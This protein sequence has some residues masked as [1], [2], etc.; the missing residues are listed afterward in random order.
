MTRVR[1]DVHLDETT[2]EA[3]AALVLLR[4]WSGECERCGKARP[5]DPHHRHLKGQGGL[6]VPSNIAA[7]CAS[8]HRWCHEHPAAA[9]EEGWIVQAPYDWRGT[10]VRLHDGRLVRLGDDYGYDVIEWSA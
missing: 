4:P 2:W 10:P 8:C 7:L 1:S 3:V 6:D 9:T 5:T